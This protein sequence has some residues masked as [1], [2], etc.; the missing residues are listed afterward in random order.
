MLAL[1]FIPELAKTYNLDLDKIVVTGDSA[2]GYS[3][4]FLC[5]L[6][7]NEDLCDKLNIP[8]AKAKLAGFMGFCGP[9]DIAGCLEHPI[10]FGLTRDIARVFLGFKLNR[11]MD[12]LGEYKYVKDCAPINFFNEKWPPAFISMAGKDFFCMGQGERMVEKYK[13]YN[14]PVMHYASTKF[15]DNHCFHL[16]FFKKQSKLCMAE[17]FKYLETIKNA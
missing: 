11:K 3:A 12:N 14:I 4:A 8:R 15:M 17:A 9:Y 1:N 16:E 10:P 13:E 2:G 6:T 5:A 7:T